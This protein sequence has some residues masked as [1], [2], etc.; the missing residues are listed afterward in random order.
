MCQI[1]MTT[2]TNTPPVTVVCPGALLIMITVL[3]ALTS[4]G[5]ITLG[6]HDV[7]LQPQL[8]QRDTVRGSAGLTNMPQQHQ[9]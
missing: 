9:S 7:V 2:T 3:L 5:Q 6:Q 8:I 4:V 1:S